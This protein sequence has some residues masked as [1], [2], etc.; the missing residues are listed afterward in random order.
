MGLPIGELA[1]YAG[2]SKRTLRYY[3]EIGLLK[4][5]KKS[6][7]GYRLYG[8]EEVNRLQQILFFRELDFDLDT[9]KAILDD[10]QF[11]RIQALEEHMQRLVEKQRHIQNL[12]LNVE[13]SLQEAR[14]VTS[15]S[16]EEKFEGFKKELIKRNEQAYGKE[17]RKKYGNEEVEASQAKLMRM[18]EESFAEFDQLGKEILKK[19]EKAEKT[20]DPGSG[21]AQEVARLHKQWLLYTWANYTKEAHANLAQRYVDDPRF[22]EHY[23]GRAEFLRDAIQIFTGIEGK[24][25]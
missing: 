15:M 6:P 5:K 22:G 13:K 24:E 25:A 21:L 23:Q 11:D 2:I 16:D 9:T 4:P 19:L 18:S 17:A 1:Q 7:S 12:L 10:P 20:K 3:D 8:K 14:G